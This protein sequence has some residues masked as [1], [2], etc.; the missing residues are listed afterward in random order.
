MS[1]PLVSSTYESPV[2]RLTLVAS[3]TGLRSV[4]WSE[5]ATDAEIRLGRT[6]VIDRTRDQLDR[7]FAGRLRDFDLPLEPIGTDFQLSA[8]NVLRTI[9]YGSTMSYGEQAAALGDPNKA[10]AVGSA[11]GRNPL[12]IVVPCHRVI[13]SSGQLTGFSGGTD[14][15]RFLLDLERRNV[16]SSN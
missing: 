2:G 4:G 11:N 15:K 12:A 5:V 1:A 9:P 13:G 10:R 8:W 14:V 6:E 16:P 3:G 7:Y